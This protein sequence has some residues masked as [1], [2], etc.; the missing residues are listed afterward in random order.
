MSTFSIKIYKE[1]FNFASAHF[2][3]FEDGAREPLHGHNYR[4]RVAVQGK[5]LEQDM[6]VDFLN[7]KP[8]VRD[9]C[10]ELDHKFLLPE[11]N[12]HIEI[13][14]TNTNVEFKTPDG[15]FYSIPLKD[16]LIVPIENISSER[17]AEYISSRLQE[18]IKSKL[19]FAFTSLEV[20]VEESPGQSAIYAINN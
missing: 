3:V 9:L 5:E 2:L 19:N 15:A 7:I 13:I 18:E 1:Y 16:T 20:E 14:K 12:K 8:I 11:K 6:V 17:L 4:V 10:N